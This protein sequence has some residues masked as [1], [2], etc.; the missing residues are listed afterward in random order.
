MASYF[1]TANADS[2]I[3]I[4]TPFNPTQSSD[5]FH[6]EVKGYAFGATQKIIDITF[7][8]YAY[9]PTQSINSVDILNQNGAHD[10]AIYQGSDGNVYLRIHPTP[11]IYYLSF[12]VDSIQ[13]GN[14]GTVEP[15]EVTVVSSAN[16]T[17]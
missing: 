2:Y 4:R 9:Y 11:S 13:V 12:R 17:L 16:S 3:H 5:M 14:G 8:G 6:F 15:G 1:T 10:P 7:T